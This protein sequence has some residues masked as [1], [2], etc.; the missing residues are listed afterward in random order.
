MCLRGAA[1]RCS[2]MQEFKN[3]IGIDIDKMLFLLQDKTPPH[4]PIVHI[5]PKRY[6]ILPFEIF[7]LY[8]ILFYIILYYLR[9]ENSNL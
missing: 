1:V 2:L 4:L 7:N 6:V 5:A 9:I 3:L 8:F